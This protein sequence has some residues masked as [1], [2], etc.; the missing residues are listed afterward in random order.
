MT[1]NA[2]KGMAIEGDTLWVADI[3][4]VR[5][6]NRQPARRSPA[7]RCR[8][9]SSSTTSRRDRTALYI[10]DTGIDI[11]A[12]GMTHP[13]PDRIFRIAGRKVTIALTFK[14]QVGPN[15]I[16]WDRRAASGSSIVPMAPAPSCAGTPGDKAPQPLATAPPMLDGVELLGGGRLLVTSWADSSLFVLDNGTVTPV[17][18]GIAAPADIGF[19]RAEAGRHAA[20]DWRTGWSCS[21]SAP[22]LAQ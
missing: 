1:L 13:G 3:D 11:G 20:T 19:D 17:A 15:G 21:T 4:A 18:A 2:P 10:T 22:S 9:P 5:G 16:T 14:G 6:F 7:S 8:G 12:G